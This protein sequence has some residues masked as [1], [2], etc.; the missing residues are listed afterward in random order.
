[1]VAGKGDRDAIGPAAA[2]LESLSPDQ[3][4]AL[5]FRKQLARN[6]VEKM[7]INASGRQLTPPDSGKVER[8]VATL[9]PGGWRV[10]EL[11][12]RVAEGCIFLNR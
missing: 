10:R 1:M 2:Q 8:I 9:K 11:I 12:H 6:P 4:S 3:R 5:T 7:L